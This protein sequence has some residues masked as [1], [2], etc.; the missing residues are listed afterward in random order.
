MSELKQPVLVVGASR[1]IGAALVKHLEESGRPVVRGYRAVSSAGLGSDEAN[2]VALDVEDEQSVSLAADIVRSRFGGVSGIVVCSGATFDD[3]FTPAASKGPLDALDATAMHR[4]FDVNAIGPMRVIRHFA[5][6]TVGA[7]LV[8]SSHRGS[9]TLTDGGGSVSYAM[10]KAALNMLIRKASF[11]LKSPT[12]VGVHPGWVATD[13]GGAEAPI[14]PEEAARMIVALL[15]SATP[16][17]HGAFVDTDGES[18]P[19]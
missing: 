8:L 2:V 18:L 14:A 3:R 10:S 4:M 19:W 11:L 15:D 12:I 9:V 6:Q 16:A 1:G 7:I 17:M 5:P 13:L